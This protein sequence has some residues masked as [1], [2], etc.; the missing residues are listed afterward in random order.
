MG[1]LPLLEYKEAFHE[2][3]KDL[4]PKPNETI[5]PSDARGYINYR[6]LDKR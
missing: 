6:G 2:L 4:F 5:I 1:R 3:K